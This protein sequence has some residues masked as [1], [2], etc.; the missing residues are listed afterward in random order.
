MFTSLLPRFALVASLL[1][2]TACTPQPPKESASASQSSAT[3]PTNGKPH[4]TIAIS[5]IVVH[6]SLDAIRQGIID[7][8]AA[9]GY[10]KGQNLTVNFQS[11]QGNTATAGQISKQFVAEKP[12]VIVA[13][14]TPTAQSLA[15]AT[16]EIP[17]VYTAVS[18][19]VAAKLVDSHNKPTQSN[20][21]GLSSQ[22]PLAPQID[23]IQKLSPTVKTIGYV[24]SAGEM[25]SVALR[26]QLK[27]EL[28]KRGLTLLDIPANRPTDIAMATNALSGKADVIYTSMDN[29]VASAF[30]AMVQSANTLKLPII[31]SDEFSVRRGGAA[32]LGVNDYDFGRTTGKMVGKILNGAPAS[33]VAPA[34]MNQLTAYI[35]PK[36][37]QA[38]GISPDMALFKDAI[39]VDSTPA[40]IIA[41]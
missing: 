5:A 14:S 3:A 16:K 6:P 35:S 21:T 36:H 15:A 31:A 40:K 8:L 39:N 37:A 24:Y 30:E 25:N 41:P 29:N 9:E 22:L 38:Q 33:Q 18:D 20:I 1:G 32:A 13:I 4:K 7:E 10:I 23:F 12:D 27:A 26:D 19:P 34:I 17:I 11:A 2:M 28:P